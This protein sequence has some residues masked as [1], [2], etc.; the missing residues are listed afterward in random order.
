LWENVRRVRAGLCR[1]GF[2]IGPVESPIVPIVIGPAERAVA[3]WRALLEAGLY[4]NIVLPPACRADA[5]MLRTSH[6]PAHS[7]AEI[8]RALIS[9][10]RWRPSNAPD[11]RC[12]SSTPPHE[13]GPHQPA[14]PRVALRRLPVA[15]P[16]ARLCR[17]GDTVALG[18]RVDR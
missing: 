1:A 18:G 5:C 3:M 12:G 13:T 17:C 6:P 10:V 14:E 9:I 11:G 4:T 7:R 15:A 8:D 2:T 16:L